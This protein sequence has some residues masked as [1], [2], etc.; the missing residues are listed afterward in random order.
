MAYAFLDQYYLDGSNAEL[1]KIIERTLVE[2]VVPDGIKR[3]GQSAFLNLFTLKKITIPE[4]V[5]IIQN[6]ALGWTAI[7]ELTLPLS[8]HTLEAQSLLGLWFAK[9]IKFGNVKNIGSGAL[10]Q[11]NA[12]VEYDFTACDSVPTLANVDAFD[13]YALKN[14]PKMLVPAA[15]Y[16]EWIAATNWA[17]YADYIVPYPLTA[18]TIDISESTLNIY[19]EEGLATS[20]DILVD[21]EVKAT[22]EKGA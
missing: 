11:Q 9:T 22:V 2:C 1:A 14:N 15:L 21:G 7:T 6:G 8:C 18:P 4:G 17:E 13:E 3:I 20:Y 12:C 19:D 10:A 16:A 5:E